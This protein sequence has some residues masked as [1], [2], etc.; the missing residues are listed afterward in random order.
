MFGTIIRQRAIP[1]RR[2]RLC[3]TRA[4][5]GD[6]SDTLQSARFTHPSYS[7]PT[8][9]FPP[10]PGAFH[11]LVAGGCMNQRVADYIR[12]WSVR[13]PCC[14][15]A[16]ARDCCYASAL[17]MR[18]NEV[19]LDLSSP[20]PRSALQIVL[21]LALNMKR[22]HLNSHSAHSHTHSEL[23]PPRS[24]PMQLLRSTCCL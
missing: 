10:K 13:P 17:W 1:L 23:R 12:M 15:G 19:Q 20:K 18:A 21:V 14:R 3:T 9:A 2:S 24:Q 5:L 11:S 16:R 6:S 22:R 7:L 4:R 8:A